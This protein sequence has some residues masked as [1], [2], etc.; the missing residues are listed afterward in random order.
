MKRIAIILCL[1]LAV[2]IVFA[3]SW[4]GFKL[5]SVCNP[6]EDTVLVALTVEEPDTTGLVG[7][8]ALYI[9]FDAN[10]LYAGD[11]GTPVNLV[12][13]NPEF[14]LANYLTNI[15]FDYPSVGWNTIAIIYAAAVSGTISPGTKL[16]DIGFYY[17]GGSTDLIFL[18]EPTFINGYVGDC[19]FYGV[20]FHVTAGG[21]NLEGAVVAVGSDSVTTNSSGLAV[22]NLPDGDYNYSVTKMG[23]VDAEG[24]FT[25][26][27]AP[28]LIEEEMEVC[29]DIILHLIDTNGTTI[30]DSAMVIVNN[31]TVWTANGS[32][33]F[34]I[35][36]DTINYEVYIDGYYPEIGEMILTPGPITVEIIMTPIFY[37][38]SFFVN[39]CGV[40]IENYIIT[41]E[42]QTVLTN[43]A[44]LAVLNLEAG[45]YSFEIGGVP[46]TFTVPDTT[47]VPVDICS[48]VTFHVT[49]DGMSIAGASVTVDNETLI[50]N[51]SGIVVFCLQ[52]GPHDFTIYYY[53]FEPITG[54]LLVN[55][56]PLLFLE[57][58]CINFPVPVQFQVTNYFCENSFDGLFV[59]C[60][61]DTVQSGGTIELVDGIYTWELIL[62]GCGTLE[63]GMIEVIS[64]PVSVEIIV[65]WLPQVT[66]HVTD[67]FNADFEGAPVCVDDDT[68]YTD[69]YGLVSF[70][71]TGGIHPYWIANPG[72]DTIYDNFIFECADTTLTV[73]LMT[74]SVKN[75]RLTLPDIYPNPSTGKFYLELPNSATASIEIRVMDLTGRKVFKEKATTTGKTEIDLSDQ[76]KGMYFVRVKFG[77]E[78]L[79]RKIVLR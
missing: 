18:N 44:G 4:D 15:L 79:T 17:Y 16:F 23:Y 33:A 66:F 59:V 65:P 20:T 6:S 22:F 69:S 78:F 34:C 77:D 76:P 14:P 45:F 62:E 24:T 50:S 43:A 57:D 58:L 42:G 63:I 35:T 56:E 41:Y 21:N 47:Y 37:D 28:L 53:A 67:Q 1:T 32:A 11:P 13:V 26:V 5:D 3:Q 73:I 64:A 46:V 71:T 52:N 61:G 25:V 12:N 60:Y 31:D 10:V 51:A 72:Y 55:N 8:F 7:T 40:P 54:Q 30:T 38:V 49:C 68:L 75:E 48:E 9:A 39:C 27:G 74:G 36:G 70:C 19:T 29:W 2:N